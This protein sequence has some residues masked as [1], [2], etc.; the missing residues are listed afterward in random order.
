MIVLIHNYNLFSLG[1]KERFV[2]RPLTAKPFLLLCLQTNSCVSFSLGRDLSAFNNTTS[3][4][5]SK[6]NEAPHR[7]LLGSVQSHEKA[8]KRP[9][10][11]DH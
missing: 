1:S 8:V 5:V 4:Y 11:E 6:A 3:L 9:Y 7:N 10:L 2:W